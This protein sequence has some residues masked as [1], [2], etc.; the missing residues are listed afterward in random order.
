TSTKPADAA[1]AAG[2]GAVAAILFG[3]VL[4]GLS[5]PKDFESRVGALQQTAS[6]AQAL[7]KTPRDAGPFGPDALCLGDAA[8]QARTLHD[9]VT[10]RAGEA[11]LTLDSLDA[12]VEPAPEVS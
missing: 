4:A 5:A 9:L 1:M 8:A 2:V 12:R 6:R 11:S 3:V 10:A 7:L